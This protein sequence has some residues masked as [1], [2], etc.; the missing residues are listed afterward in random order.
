MEDGLGSANTRRA[1]S[2][3]VERVERGVPVHDETLMRLAS[4]HESGATT[5][6]RCAALQPVN[7]W[8]VFYNWTQPQPGSDGMKV[9]LTGGA[10]DLGTV[11]TPLL[12]ARGDTP[13]RLDI[14]HYRV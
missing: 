8:R 3:R 9:V 1:M 6:Q 4:V 5:A 2:R 11:L 13:L 12:E 14:R 10:G 7:E